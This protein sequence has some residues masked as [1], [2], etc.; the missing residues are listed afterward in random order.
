MELFAA[1]F[2]T[3]FRLSRR[4]YSM[5]FEGVAKASM[6]GAVRIGKEYNLGA[7]HNYYDDAVSTPGESGMPKFKKLG[8]QA[9]SG[10]ALLSLLGLALTSPTKTGLLSESHARAVA[11]GPQLISVQPLSAGD[12][13]MCQWVPASATENLFAELSEE[14]ESDSAGGGIPAGSNKRPESADRKPERVIRD[15][16]PTYAGIALNLQKDEVLLQDENLFGIKVFNRLDNTPAK[17][18]FTEPKRAIAGGETTKLQFNCGIYVDPVTGDIYSVTNDTINTM[19]VFPWDAKGEQKPTRELRTPHSTYGISVDENAQEIYLTVQADNSV[20]VY[21]KTAKDRDQPI[22]TLEGDST[23]LSDPHGVAV[24]Y[25]HKLMFVS[26]HGNGVTKATKSGR[27]DP[28]SITVYPLN[29]SGDVAPI[30][31]I[32]GANTRLNW[33]AA[34]W[35]DSE[36]GELY[37]A[38]DADDSVVVFKTDDDGDAKPARVIRGPK[39]GIKNPT[40]V[41]LD[42]KHDELWVSNMGSHAA[43]VYRRTANG[44]VPPLRTIRSAPA[45]MKALAIGN[46]GAVAYDPKRDEILAPN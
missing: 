21:P 8:I 19:T 27:F 33:P 4:Q 1:D 2:H 28:P 14:Q 29:A 30:R 16:F 20:V 15:T 7:C 39:S 46:P 37:V 22:R 5:S 44:D 32:R 36:H 9:I 34:M 45:D 38:N 24:D 11:G 25:Q 23:Q 26:N 40:G 43:T 3:D 18:A 13:E 35:V 42:S 10:I 17:A 6:G 41:F 12:G 31:Q